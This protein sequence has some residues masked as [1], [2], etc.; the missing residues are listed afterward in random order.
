MNWFI[1]LEQFDELLSARPEP[2]YVL[3]LVGLLSLLA[4][5]LPFVMLVKSRMEYWAKNSSGH[6]LPRQGKIQLV[7]PFSGMMGGLYILI[8][9]SLEILGLP[10][11]PSLFFSL[12]VILLTSYLTWQQL[13]RM[14]SR[15]A[16]RYHLDEHYTPQL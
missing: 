3:W 4:C 13:G 8:A 1:S 9:S 5:M 10:I 16:L 11:L 15:Q 12:L 6:A 14:L 7:L 2:P